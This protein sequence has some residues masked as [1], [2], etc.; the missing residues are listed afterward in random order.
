[1]PAATALFACLFA[2]KKLTKTHKSLQKLENGKSQMNPPADLHPDS[3]IAQPILQTER[4]ILRAFTLD[5]APAVN[6]LLVDKEIAAN[7]QL[8]PFPYTLEMA[9][10]WIKPQKQ[11][12][13]EGRAAVFAICLD[14]PSKQG[15][16][17]GAVGLEIDSIH[18]RAEMGYWLGKDYWGQ[19]YCTEAATALV[20]FGFRQLGLNRIFAYHMTR[21]PASGR[22]LEKLGMTH[23]GILKQ[24]VKKWG[25]FENVALL[26]ILRPSTETE[27]T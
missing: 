16:V 2:H 13:Q 5:D 12:W 26:G 20:E 11:I 10:E 27:E 19:G 15:R 14:D 6:E 25:Q 23:E 1:M 3:P 8:I 9:T 21:N 22:V 7:T 24:H 17:V 18:E 4:L